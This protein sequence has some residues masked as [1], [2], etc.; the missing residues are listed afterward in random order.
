MGCA[1]CPAGAGRLTAPLWSARGLVIA[2]I[3]QACGV[4]GASQQS[5]DETL[6]QVLQAQQVLLVL[7]N[8]EHL[9]AA[10]PRVA[11]LLAACPELTVLA[12]SRSSLRLRTYLGRRLLRYL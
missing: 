12:T 3:A 2:A 4:Q 11:A 5:L 10:A 1:G 7:D 6:T 8:V 9:L